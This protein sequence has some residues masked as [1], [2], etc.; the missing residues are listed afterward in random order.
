LG[1]SDFVFSKDASNRQGEGFSYDFTLER[2]DLNRVLYL[3]LNYRIDSPNY[4]EGDLTVWLLDV[5][6][7]QIYTVQDNRISGGSRALYQEFPLVGDSLQYRLIF[8]VSTTNALA[9]DFVFNNI[10]LSP[11]TSYTAGQASASDWQAYTPTFSGA[12]TAGGISFAYRRSG[13]NIDI[14][15]I[16]RFTNFVDT[17]AAQVTLPPGMVIDYPFSTTRQL[18]GAAAGGGQAL[19]A[20]IGIGARSGDA[21]F[22]FIG[23]MLSGNNALTEL[24][25]NVMMITNNDLVVNL[26][27]PIRG[28]SGGPFSA[29]PRVYRA[30]SWAASGARVTTTPTSLG[31]WRAYRRLANGN[32]YVDSGHSTNPSTNSGFLIYGNAGG[33]AAADLA[34]QPTRYDIFVGRNKFIS[35]EFFANAN[36]TGL[37]NVDDRLSGTLQIGCRTS[38]DPT[39]GIASITQQASAAGTSQVAGLLPDLT[40][41]N[42]AYF[43]IVIAEHPLPLQFEASKSEVF[44][45]T[46]AGFGTGA[47]SGVRN[48]SAIGRV[49]GND[50][51]YAFSATLGTV[52]TIEKDGI[53]SFSATDSSTGSSGFGWTRNSA[54]INFNFSDTALAYTSMSGA[55]TQSVTCPSIYCRAGDKFRVVS[56][57][58]GQISALAITA[59][60]RVSRVS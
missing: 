55:Q 9:W 2:A 56:D 10:S 35:W 31:Q 17:V 52:I 7:N 53:Y 40:Q 58:P 46:G 33:I 36:R 32:T 42:T 44:L 41:S 5:T 21:Y 26:S 51:S 47:N 27:V 54:T 11:T 38:Y 13:G 23:G 49:V 19:S 4:T 1:D 30:S 50:I 18:A 6:N 39:T 12:G 3:N 15:G 22:S 25:W 34:N 14:R 48:Y 60:L 28:L 57:A 37:V 29:T 59:R 45:R 16:F 43:D 24:P 20:G 8:H